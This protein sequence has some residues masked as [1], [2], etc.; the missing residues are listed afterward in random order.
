MVLKSILIN[1]VNLNISTCCLLN[2]FRVKI[3]VINSSDNTETLIFRTLPTNENLKKI[4]KRL[5][6]G[7]DDVLKMGSNGCFLDKA[8]TQISHNDEYT[9]SLSEILQEI[10]NDLTLLIEQKSGLNWTKL[11][12]KFNYGFIFKDD[13]IIEAPEQA[14]E[15]DVDKVTSKKEIN[16]PD[17][18]DKLEECENELDTLTKKNFVLYGGINA[19][20]PWLSV[21]LGVS[22]EESKRKL[23]NCKKSTIYSITRIKRA[24]IVLSKES[25]RLKPTFIG[26]IENILNNSETNNIDKI[27]SLREITKKYGHFYASDIVFGGATVKIQIN[28]TSSSEI[29]EVKTNN[30]NIAIGSIVQ[31]GFTLKTMK[32]TKAS[33]NNKYL[34]V[35][36][37]GDELSKNYDD[38]GIVE[39]DRIKPIF[40]LLDDELQRKIREVL[41]YRILKANV[42]EIKVDWDVSKKKPH[43]H[44]F[45]DKLHEIPN[46]HECQIFASIMN[47]DDENVFSLRVDYEDKYSPVI[48]VHL[49]ASKKEKS[50]RYSTQIG[51]IVVGYPTNFDFDQAEY[52]ITLRGYIPEISKL[53]NRYIADIPDHNSVPHHLKTR[54]LSTC[55]LEAPSSK[56]SYNPHNTTIVIGTHFTSS[57]H[58]AC[59]FACNING[60]NELVNDQSVMKRLK[61][62]CW[63][64]T[65]GSK[66]FSC[67]R[68]ENNQLFD[69]IKENAKHNKQNKDKCPVFAYHIF[70]CSTNCNR[71]GFINIT[72]KNLIHGSLNTYPLEKEMIRYF[73]VSPKT[74]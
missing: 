40:D 69:N 58:L 15:V 65:R 64:N 50:K 25:I 33:G 24:S 20:T 57:N 18:S 74:R 34:V 31:N 70:D 38:W 14:F 54:M 7:D 26:E 42:E 22:H 29:T 36:I 1:E 27:N 5:N 16:P 13:R 4:R 53:S 49:V 45:A 62:F 46:R 71:H 2:F 48:L 44:Q 60:N 63:H 67:K 41:G 52:P 35:Q 12:K 61:L 51:W 3:K 59:L 11:I 28:T 23:K 55:I 6:E 47:K 30:S 9:T 39:Y 32:K 72:S 56:T 19:I 10:N 8:K 37:I 66:I 73:A 68:N 21:F 17:K 43:V